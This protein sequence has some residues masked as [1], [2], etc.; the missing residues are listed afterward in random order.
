MGEETVWVCEGR[1]GFWMW[2]VIVM[3]VLGV[4][5]LWAVGEDYHFVDAEDGEGTGEVTC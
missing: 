1:V 5:G 4:C 2:A 3:V